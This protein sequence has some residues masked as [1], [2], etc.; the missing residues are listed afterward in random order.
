MRIH[1]FDEQTDTLITTR[2]VDITK[3]YQDGQNAVLPL[4]EHIVLQS[5]SKEMLLLQNDG[6][7][8]LWSFE[9]EQFR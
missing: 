3:W 5:G 7:G 1:T 4:I 6:F 9:R 8:R 2:A